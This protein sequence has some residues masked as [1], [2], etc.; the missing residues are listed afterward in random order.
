MYRVSIPGRDVFPLYN[1]NEYCI[2][3]CIERPTLTG[4]SA[5]QHIQHLYLQL[6][7]TCYVE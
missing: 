4:A 2:A 7:H 3:Y 6:Q 5:M 1:N